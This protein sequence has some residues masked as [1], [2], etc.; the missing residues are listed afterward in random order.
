[1]R[2]QQGIVYGGVDTHLDVHVAA[3]IDEA[4]TLLG[5]KSF[6]THPLGLRQAQRWLAR[7]GQ[8]AKVGV[9]GTGTYGLGLTRVLQAAGHEVVEV[10]RPNRQLRRSKGK[11][12]TVDAEAAARAAMAGHATSV[13]KSRDGIVEC[14]RVL[15]LADRSAKEQMNRLA[16]QVANLA[17]CAPEGIRVDL[18]GL[19]QLAR[20]RT[21]A[22][23]RPGT[24]IA[25]VACATKTAMRSLARQWLALREDRARY[26]AQI[27]ELTARANPALMQIHCVG[28]DVAAAILIAAGDNPGRLRSSAAFAALAG[29]SPIQASSGKKTGHRLNRGGDRQANAAIHRIVLVRMSHKDPRTIDYIARRTAQGHSKRDIIRCLKR[30]VAREVYQALQHPQP[31]TVIGTLRQRR[32]AAGLPMKAVAQHFNRPINAIARLERGIVH[33][34][35]LAT[36]YHAWLDTHGAA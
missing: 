23:Y 2:E 15:R 22:A 34:T 26:R 12:D 3:V 24:D 19:S 30:Y 6:P 1:M 17:V 27:A 18:Q 29:V 16:G 20:A 9:E 33:D 35:D 14:L 8:V 5:T 25:D 21:M 4:G 11:S 36:R 7:H 32:Q 28:P 10:N 13:P 31:T